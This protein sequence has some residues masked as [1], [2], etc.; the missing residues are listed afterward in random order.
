MGTA[1]LVRHGESTWN[2]AGRAQG[3]APTPLT[4]RGREQA[5]AVAT[6]IVRT[7]DVDRLVTSDLR[8]AADTAAHIADAT[9]VDPEPDRAWRERDFG[10]LQGLDYPGLFEAF[11]RFSLDERGADAVAERPASGE[12][13]LDVHD[14]VLDGWAALVDDLA[15]DDTAV[16]VC[17]G[18]PLHLLTGA[19]RGVDVPTAV[20]DGEQDNCAITEIAVDDGADPRLVRENWTGY[21]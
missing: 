2:R 5:A 7:H 10:R 3:W 12:S 11:P 9:G 1:L 15:P 17:H 4:D 8:R 20:L 18:G 19:V 16:V 6:Y 13:L 21:R 14:R